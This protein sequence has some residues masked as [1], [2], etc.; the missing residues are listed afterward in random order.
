MISMGNVQK[1]RSFQENVSAGP[2]TR[3]CAP[4]EIVDNFV[5]LLEG[6]DF[7]QELRCLKVGRFNM[8]LR[9]N[10]FLELKATYAGLWALALERSFPE[11]G[12]DIFD[13]F[14]QSYT[15]S[16]SS[17]DRMSMQNK[18]NDY[19]DMALNHGDKD[20][21]HISKHLLSFGKVPVVEMKAE[22][23]RLSLILRQHYIF[24]FERL[25]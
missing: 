24:L 17:S 14:V 19:R 7:S 25:V 12:K 1:L 2:V 10:M 13:I 5:K 15:A 3:V 16:M 8:L 4:E 23:L 9:R 18:I 20:F 6:A 22:V 21:S 11:T